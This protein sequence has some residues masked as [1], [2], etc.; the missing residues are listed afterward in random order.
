[1]FSYYGSKSKIV[2]FYPKPKLDKIIEP[3]AGSAR[4]ALRYFDRDILLIDKY[5]VLIDVWSYLK[6]VS[7]K[8]LLKLSN[9]KLEYRLSDL[10]DKNTIEYKF[11]GYLVQVGQGNPKDTLSNMVGVDYFKKQIKNIA[12]Q[13]YKIRHWKI[14]KDDYQ[15]LKNDEAVW[16]IDPPYQ[17]GGQYQ[18]K[19]NNKQIDFKSLANWC[20]SRKGQVIVCE[21][22]K[23]D[24]M[25]FIPMTKMRGSK[26]TTTEAIWSNY[27][28]DYNNQKSLF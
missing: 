24:W 12:S 27:K 21:N 25:P 16:F 8:E 19:F 13:L 3:F 4:Y 7:E 6:N 22:T 2:D 23:A 28:T 1:M 15:N 5:D 18:Y 20:K 14:K 10:L 9:L 17:H 11:L 26:F